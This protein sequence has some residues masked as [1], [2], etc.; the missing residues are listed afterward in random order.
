M[1]DFVMKFFSAGKKPLDFRE[2]MDW[3]KEHHKEIEGRRIAGTALGRDGTAQRIEL[4][5]DDELMEKVKQVWRLR[6][7][8][9]WLKIADRSVI[10][11]KIRIGKHGEPEAFEIERQE[12]LPV[13]VFT[14][15]QKPVYWRSVIPS[16]SEKGWLTQNKP[17][18][19]QHG[20]SGRLY[21]VEG[22]T[23]ALAVYQ[24][25][26]EAD[27]LILGTAQNAEKIPQSLANRY[28]EIYIATDNDEAGEKAYSQ[29]KKILP[30]AERLRY[31]GK[32]PMEAWLEGELKSPE[33]YG[34]EYDEE[35]LEQVLEE[36][37]EM[38]SIARS[39]LG[40]EEEY[41]EWEEDEEEEYEEEQ[42]KD[43]GE[44]FTPGPGM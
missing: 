24:I 30:K 7:I 43:R 34:E 38:R 4:I 35:L 18:L 17:A 12:P 3:L 27:I 19:K 42:R 11:H 1:I 40:E 36:L 8:P 28:E 21:I 16:K 5:E 26:T 9:F 32:D 15:Q 41:E 31:E 29:L 10:R 37:E 13:L 22:Y 33:E 25:D 39:I 44:G 20:N 23:D 2:A 14:H 6:H